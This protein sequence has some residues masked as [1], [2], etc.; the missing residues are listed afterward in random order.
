MKVTG[1]AFIGIRTEQFEATCHFFTTLLELDVTRRE[2][3]VAGF[4]M[5]GHTTVEVYG[6]GDDFHSFFGEGPVIGFRVENFDDAY[7]ELMAAG[8][9]FISTIQHES[10]ISWNHF[11]GPDGNIYEIVGPGQPRDE[12]GVPVTKERQP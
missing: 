12:H 11:R 3:D 1:I 5:A 8:I 2:P 6:P 7:A 9:E 10:G 4:R